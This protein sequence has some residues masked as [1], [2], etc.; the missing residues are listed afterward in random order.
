MDRLRGASL[1][2]LALALLLAAQLVAGPPPASVQAEGQRGT[3][4]APMLGPLRPLF[5]ELMLVHFQLR[6]E[7]RQSF[8]LLEEAHGILALRP[9][10][11]DLWLHMATLFAIDFGFRS[12]NAS[13]R[14]A[15]FQAGLR[16]FQRGLER[17]PE[18]AIL[19]LSL[20][21]TLRAAELYHP[22]LHEAA[23]ELF[24]TSVNETILRS[25]QRALAVAPAQSQEWELAR[26]H[27]GRRVIH[28]L[29]GEGLSEER[30]Q[31][32]ENLARELLDSHV[33]ALKPHHEIER[34]LQ[35]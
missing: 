28:E 9:D 29:E 21:Q 14:V 31:E 27:L 16:L 13:T 19:W 23:A 10:R 33:L 6:S 15:W 35:D 11:V 12:G 17:L 5:A 18:A 1:V 25:F 32:V 8:G 7:R 3:L 22:D 26:L 4:L 30:R 24:E 34:L 2:A 20:G